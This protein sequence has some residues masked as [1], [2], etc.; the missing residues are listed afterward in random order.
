M[1]SYY[2]NAKQVMLDLSLVDA[3]LKLDK[4]MK[5]SK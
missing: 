3:A 1:H 2:K 4:Q 5:V